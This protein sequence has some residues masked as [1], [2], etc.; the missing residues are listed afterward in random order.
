M[1]LGPLQDMV[2][3][4]DPKAVIVGSSHGPP[5]PDTV[6][7]PGPSG[8]DFLNSAYAGS[9]TDNIGAYKN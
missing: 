8:A 9:R 1:N 5:D 6:I 3:Q 2:Y 7:Y 4:F